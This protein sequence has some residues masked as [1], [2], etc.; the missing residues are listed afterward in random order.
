MAD[1]GD[2]DYSHSQCTDSVSE[3]PRLSYGLDNLQERLQEH[4]QQLATQAAEV[5]Q[6]ERVKALIRQQL[7]KR[8]SNAHTVVATLRALGIAIDGFPPFSKSNVDKA[9]R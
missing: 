6:R 5:Q 8:V 4:R 7:Q 2:C 9:H 3:S 1:A